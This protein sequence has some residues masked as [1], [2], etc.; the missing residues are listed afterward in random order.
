MPVD[1]ARDRWLAGKLPAKKLDTRDWLTPQWLY[2][3]DHMPKTLRGEQLADLD[4]AFG[5][6]RSE[7]R[8]GDPQLAHAGDSQRIPAEL[9]RGSRST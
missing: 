5:F 3:L 1:E 2:F 8:A 9:S 7:Q 4:Q 6:T